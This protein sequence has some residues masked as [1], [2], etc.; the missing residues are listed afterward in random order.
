MLKVIRLIMLTL[1]MKC[2]CIFSGGLDSVSSAAYM[3][4][5]GYELYL[6]TFD[7]GQKA[8]KE[9]S[10]AKEFAKTLGEHKIVDISFMKDIYGESN[11][12]TSPGKIP[13]SFD[14][15]IVVPIRNMIFLTIG[16]AWAFSIKASILA[17][18]AHL[19][20]K[21]YPDCREE[22][23]KSLEHT[24]NLAEDDGIRKGLRREITIWSPVIEGLTKVD[25]VRIGYK[26]LGDD[27]FKTWSCYDNNEIHCGVCESCNNRKNAFRLADINDKTE[28]ALNIE[29][30]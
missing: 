27:I 3:K 21:N 30:R 23:T 17:Y 26:L 20:D 12:L 8:R 25:M 11:V 7:Y 1:S 2:V 10:I 22:F 6:I 18:G 14:Y 19:D 4:N 29:R 15:S 5:K 16:G 13:S 9:L 24:F 28:Y